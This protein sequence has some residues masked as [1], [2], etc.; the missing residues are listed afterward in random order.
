[1]EEAL[2]AALK[3]F[4]AMRAAEGANLKADVLGKLETLEKYRNRIAEHAPSVP[5]RLR[6]AHAQAPGGSGPFRLRG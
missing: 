6:E 4:L 1:M 5:V 3:D 2:R